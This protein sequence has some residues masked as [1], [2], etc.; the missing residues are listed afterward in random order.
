MP[1]YMM[2]ACPKRMWYVEEFLIPSM[3]EQGIPR[4]DITVW[5]DTEKLGN[6]AACMAAFESCTGDGGT[7]HLQDDVVISADF[8]EKTREFDRG[9]VY[10]FCSR[11]FMDD[12][13]IAG[14]VYAEDAW[15]S[16]QCV[17]IPNE[18][19]R[20]CAAWVKAGGPFSAE[21]EILIKLN[22]GDDTLFREYFITHH[23]M[24]TAVNLSPNIVN[25]VDYLV[26]GPVTNQ[27]RS[28][29]VGSD[30]W[31]DSSIISKLQTKLKE[32]GR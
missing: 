22:K 21:G 16:F 2:H 19:A 4:E 3:L 6:L 25:H 14:E 18:Y 8:A 10:G 15:H 28:Y 27:W 23:G 1:K 17:R 12:V 26:G 5:N 13:D 30:K 9:V 7:W 29:I 24:D 11:Y 31:A 32:R 20:G